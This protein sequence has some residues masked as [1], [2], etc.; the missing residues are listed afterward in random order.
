MIISKE[1]EK[2]IMHAC[3]TICLVIQRKM[4]LDIKVASVMQ[5]ALNHIKKVQIGLPL[6]SVSMTQPVFAAPDIVRDTQ[7]FMVAAKELINK[8][9]SEM[10]EFN[11]LLDTMEEEIRLHNGKQMTPENMPKTYQYFYK[12]YTWLEMS[13]T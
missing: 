8:N 3:R 5:T 7:M 1:T 9:K 11:N 6:V 12:L 10:L 4:A 13:G 2:I